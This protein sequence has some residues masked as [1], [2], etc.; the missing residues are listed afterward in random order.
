[1]TRCP[2]TSG[3]SPASTRTMPVLP[4]PLGPVISAPSPCRTAS[5]SLRARTLPVGVTTVTSLRPTEG[6]A[7][8]VGAEMVRAVAE[9]WGRGRGS[10][11]VGYCGIV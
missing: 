10:G 11:L 2:D 4:D 9:R 8:A 3:H 6:P 5:V 7:V 1:M